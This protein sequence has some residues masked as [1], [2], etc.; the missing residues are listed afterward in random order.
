MTKAEQYIQ[1]VTDGSKIVCT[2][3]KQAVQRHLN[4]LKRDDIYFDPK[5]AARAIKFFSFLK[6]S[7]GRNFAGKEFELS[8][9][10]E[11]IIYCLFGWKNPDGSRRFTMSYTEVAKK[12]GKSTL[13]A[14]IG[15]YMMISDGEPG[16]EIY[17][18]ATMRDQAKIV[19]NEA[20][21]MV[22]KSPHLTKRVEVFAHNLHINETNSKFEALGADYDSF[23]GKNPYCCIVDEY[24]AHKD[25]KLFDNIRAATVSRNQSL[26]WVITTAGVNK[27]YPCYKFR[28][29]C[30]DVLE[31][32]LID[33]GLFT[34]IFT[35]DSEE[36]WDKPEL[37]VK[38]NPNLN[39]SVIEA[40]LKSE[41]Q[42]AK[43]NPEGAVMFKT[44]NMNIWTDSAM[45]WIPDET[46]QKCDQGKSDYKGKTCYGALDLAT[47]I[48]LA[49]FG[50][51]WEER[52]DDK[53]ILNFFPMFFIPEDTLQERCRKDHV[54]YDTW[55]RDAYIIPTPGNVIDYDYI[56]SY[57]N[58]VAKECKLKS[59]QFDRFNSSQLVIQ[60]QDDGLV[61]NPFG[62]GY[63]SMSAPTKELEKKV[64]AQEINHMGNPVMRWM[65]GNVFI[66]VDPAGNYKID[67]SK[68]SEKVDGMVTL[69]M[70]LGGYMTDTNKGSVYDKRGFIEI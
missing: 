35:Q 7:K 42:A 48:D 29:I 49:C 17:S 44:K 5:A 32:K 30:K 68:S 12:N 43:N 20:A 64:L 6:H 10:Q 16:A 65:N 52:R 55:A 66:R 57:V 67:K 15:L 24:H 34:I 26:I 28:K 9:W 62:Q 50:L 21:N 31:G 27:E 56:R 53:I 58:K 60:L 40:K 33:D 13:A 23:E 69:V 18:A 11:F 37:W 63:V 36:E 38:S 61:M 39:V 3:V 19:F 41:Y 46:W 22:K 47:V 8:D 25:S 54:N 2:E 45:Q 1:Q 4:D 70:A 14:G 59:I 51:L